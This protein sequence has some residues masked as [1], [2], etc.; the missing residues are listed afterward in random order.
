MEPAPDDVDCPH[1]TQQHLRGLGSHT[2]L[3][4]GQLLSV[5]MAN[6]V[7]V[8]NQW[9]GAGGRPTGK[10]HLTAKVMLHELTLATQAASEPP[11]RNRKTKA[12]A[13]VVDTQNHNQTQG[14]VHQGRTQTQSQTQ[15]Q[16]Q[17]QTQTQNPKPPVKTKPKPA[18][19]LP[20]KPSTIKPV[21]LKPA[22]AKPVKPTVVKHAGSAKPVVVK[23]A[24][25]VVSTP[26]V[27]L[28]PLPAAVNIPHELHVEADRLFRT[29]GREPGK[30]QRGHTR[31]AFACVFTACDRLGVQRSASTLSRQFGLSRSDITEGLGDFTALCP[32]TERVMALGRDIHSE[33]RTLICEQK[34]CPPDLVDETL[35]VLADLVGHLSKSSAMFDPNDE[36]QQG[37]KRLALGVLHYW[38]CYLEPDRTRWPQLTSSDLFPQDDVMAVV[39]EVDRCRGKELFGSG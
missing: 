35:G 28:L 23:Q 37:R 17:N 30:P 2:C 29:L 20:P 5:D 8:G 14:E 39:R 12:L 25:V 36:V 18:A 24:K 34:R 32:Q 6:D 3:D 21:K 9:S 13:Q 15:T 27:P 4:C 16:N 11:V 31:L 22:N 7:G 26:A 38:D 10:H 33:L 1:L 19:S